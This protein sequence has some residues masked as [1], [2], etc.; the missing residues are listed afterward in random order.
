MLLVYPIMSYYTASISYRPNASLSLQGLAFLSPNIAGTFAHLHLDPQLFLR[1]HTPCSTFWRFSC[2]WDICWS[3][4]FISWTMVCT[5]SVLLFIFVILSCSCALARRL[6]TTY[7]KV[8]SP[9]AGLKCGYYA[10]H[11]R[12]HSISF[13]RLAGVALSNLTTSFIKFTCIHITSIKALPIRP[14]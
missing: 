8:A 6:V 12:F 2:N 14:W 5:L 9:S 11:C 4:F 7:R 3:T 1:L 13:Q 10:S